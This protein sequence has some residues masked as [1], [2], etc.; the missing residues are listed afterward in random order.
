[1]AAAYHYYVVASRHAGNATDPSD[2]G[3][4][5]DIVVAR[6]GPGLGLLMSLTVTA[7]ESDQPLVGGVASEVVPTASSD[8]VGTKR[9]HD[10][11]QLLWFW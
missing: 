10:S 11:L 3:R 1:V 5:S 2:D 9:I 7:G 6:F 8:N 4:P